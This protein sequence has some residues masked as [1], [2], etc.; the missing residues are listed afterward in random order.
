MFKVI[1]RKCTG[2]RTAIF[3]TKRIKASLGK[4]LRENDK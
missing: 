2:K 4:Q 3:Q 1:K